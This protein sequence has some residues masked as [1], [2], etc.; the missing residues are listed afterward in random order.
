M[1]KII[2]ALLL[3]TAPAFAAISANT[4]WEVRTTGS[5]TNSGGFVAG[6]SG[7]D[8]SQFDN[9]NAA[10]CTSCQ[11]STINI[12]TTDAV[13]AGTTTVTSATA[14][15]SAAIVGNLVYLSG[16]TGS[17][18]GAWYQVV[19]F[20]NVTTIVLDRSTGLSA[21]TGA[22]INIGGA[23]A[24]FGQLAINMVTSNQAYV[25]AGS[26][27]TSTATNTFIGTVT[28]GQMNAILGYGTTRGDGGMVT[29][30]L[31]TNTGLK[32]LTSTGDGWRI[33]NITVDCASLGTSTAMSFTG[34]YGSIFNAVAKNCTSN[35]IIATNNIIAQSESSGQSGGTGISGASVLD[36]YVHDSVSSING[37]TIGNTGSAINNLVTNLA[38]SNSVGIRLGGYSSIARNNTMYSIGGSC[39]L[40]F[41]SFPIPAYIR[42]NIMEKCSAA[43]GSAWGIAA[44]NAMPAQPLL[45]GNYYLKWFAL[46]NRH[47]IDDVSGV[48]AA[49]PYTNTL[50]RIGSAE[51]FNNSSGG[52]FSLNN[53]VGG[54]HEIRGYS[55]PSKQQGVSGFQGYAD[56]GATQHWSNPLSSAGAAVHV[57]PFVSSTAPPPPITYA[58]EGDSITSGSGTMTLVLTY[59]ADAL[60][61][62]IASGLGATAITSYMNYTNTGTAGKKCSE[63]TARYSSTV[64]PLYNASSSKNVASIMC[65]S[66]AESGGLASSAYTQIQAW[67]SAAKATGFTVLV[68]LVPNATGSDAYDATLNG[69]IIAGAGAGGYT[70]FGSSGTS[71]M[72]CNGCAAN[73]TY[74]QDGLHPTPLGATYIAAYET[75]AFAAIGIN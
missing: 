44:T 23:L 61:G 72:Y 28:P 17:I 70:V 65:G 32:G 49:G 45:D 57:A 35:G 59:P 34:S 51:P 46:S 31:S 12:S 50:D 30:T 4:V 10:A 11:S 63:L 42:N 24:T 58:A 33:E 13:T 6:A 40:T 75:L 73:T 2:L 22:T 56:M 53:A 74:F 5:D 9:K 16:G 19:T 47:N 26:G 27:Y 15:F 18:A 48:N 3:C 43:A 41:I 67:V 71:P 8:M 39:M 69:L 25:K 64:A 68:G 7:T 14:N 21:G 38:G 52:V 66:N 29:L 37:I 54:G 62:N 55:V 1:K 36:S 20:T 60:D